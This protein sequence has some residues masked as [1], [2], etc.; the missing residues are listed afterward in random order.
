MKFSIIVPEKVSLNTAMRKHYR[1]VNDLKQEWHMAVIDAKPPKWTGSFPVDIFFH[2]RLKGRMIDSTN[3]GFMS[4]ACE[5][6]L[7]SYGVFP[8]DNPKFIRR[9]TNQ[10]DQDLKAKYD[11][12][13]VTISPID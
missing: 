8:D 5:D 10:T 12:V 11:T 2:Y 7:V 6:A 1:V 4:K 3:A 9:S 13:E